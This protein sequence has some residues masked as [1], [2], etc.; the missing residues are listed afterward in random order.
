MHS[1]LELLKE[2]SKTVNSDIIPEKE[3]AQI[4]HKIKELLDMLWKYSE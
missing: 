4:K 2:L 3:K 1:Y